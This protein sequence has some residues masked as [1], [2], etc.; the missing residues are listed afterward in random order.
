MADFDI[1][2]RPGTIDDVPLLLA[3]MRMMAEFEKLEFTATEQSL[4]ASLFSEQPAATTLIAFVDGKPAGYATYFFSFASSVGRRGLWLDD[5]F[6]HPD[7]RGTGLGKALVKYIAAIAVAN[8]C[9]RF[10]W[11]VLGWNDS[12]VGFYESLGARV[13][14]D[15]RIYRLDGEE[16]SKTAGHSPPET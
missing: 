15:W 16:L 4:R 12:A 8:D 3:F 5:V 2:F 14:G 13:L 6:V 7:Y 1:E 10:E 9:A 11:M